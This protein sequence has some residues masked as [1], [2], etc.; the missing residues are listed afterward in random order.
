MKY[1]SQGGQQGT[2]PAYNGGYSPQVSEAFGVPSVPT[3]APQSSAKHDQYSRYMSMA[4]E[5]DAAGL[6][7]MANKYRTN[8]IALMPKL[9]NEETR[10][11]GGKAVVVRNYEDGTTEVSPFNP[12]DKKEYQDIGG[13]LIPK[14]GITGDL[15]P[16]SP[17]AKTVT[18]GE[19]L[20][21]NTTRRGQDL[22]NSLGWFNAKKPTFN[23]DAGGF[24]N[25]PTKDNPSGSITLTPGYNKPLNGEQSNAAMFG[26]R[27]AR[28]NELLNSLETGGI[29]NPGIIKSAAESVPFV[30]GALGSGINTLPGALGGPNQFQQQTDQ[31]RRDFV[32]AVL[33]KES[34]AAISQSEFD[35]ANRQ[36][37]PQPGDSPAVIEQK[38]ANRALEIKTLGLG[39]GSGTSAID[40]ATQQGKKEGAQIKT[41]S[42]QFD[43]DGGKVLAKLG[44]DGNYYVKKG[45]KTYRV[46][47]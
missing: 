25:Q 39:A 16:G 2:P 18:P 12:V 44:N 38:R 30:G 45:G 43:V 32:N 42:K 6:P 41:P 7:E 46:Q 40:S 20:S 29:T 17:L 19:I 27:A 47:E 33:R 37:F 8:A 24:V 3:Q 9:K 36:Y 14:S 4:D 11:Q 13:Q 23:A 34:G 28:A 35:N 31:A 22:T 10:M 5:F 1:Q 26:A 21:S 15:L